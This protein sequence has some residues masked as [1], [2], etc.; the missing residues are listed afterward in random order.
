MIHYYLL[1][2]F[3]L[4]YK[5]DSTRR[6]AFEMVYKKAAGSLEASSHCVAYGTL[7]LHGRFRS[8]HSSNRVGFRRRTPEGVSIQS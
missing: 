6:E 4:R 5:I 2:L 1:L 3:T 7:S 8:R